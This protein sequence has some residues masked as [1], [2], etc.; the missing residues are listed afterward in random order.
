MEK[1]YF[2]LINSI[3]YIYIKK[4]YNNNSKRRWQVLFVC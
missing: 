1:K 4:K 2:K 3:D